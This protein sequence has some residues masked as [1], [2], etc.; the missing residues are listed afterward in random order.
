MCEN[1]SNLDQDRTQVAIAFGR[2]ATATLACTETGSQ[3]RSPPTRPDVPRSET[4]PYLSLSRDAE[5]G[6]GTSRNARNSHEKRETFLKRGQEPRHFPLQQPDT[7]LPK[8]EL[9]Q[10]LREQKPMMGFQVPRLRLLQESDLRTH[11]TAGQLSQLQRVTFS[12]NEGFKHL[13]GTFADHITDQRA[14][15]D[16]G[17]FQD[18]VDAIDVSV[19]LLHQ[20]GVG[21]H[22]VTQ[23]PNGLGGNKAGGSRKPWRKRSAIHSLS[24]LSVLRPGMACIGWAL[25]NKISSRSS[26][27]LKMGRQ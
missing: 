9:G 26:S 8:I 2:L 23:F 3:D 22:Q 20:M 1:P 5:N 13:P 15:L 12:C 18:L 24:L 11:P 6:G 21:A 17:R 16:M 4:P 14:Q 27:R 19:P 7:R 25:T 10:G